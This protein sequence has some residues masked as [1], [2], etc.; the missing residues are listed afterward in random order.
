M[1][2]GLTFVSHNPQVRFMNNNVEGNGIRDAGSAQQLISQV[3]FNGM[4]CV[5]GPLCPDPHSLSLLLGTDPSPPDLPPCA[6]AMCPPLKCRTSTRV[7]LPGIARLRLMLCFLIHRPLGTALESKV[8][9][10]FLVSGLQKRDLQ[11]PILVSPV[12]FLPATPTVCRCGSCCDNF[13]VSRR[14]FT[15]HLF[16][17]MYCAARA[18]VHRHLRWRAC[19][20]APRHRQAR[21]PA[22]AQPHSCQR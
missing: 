13:A 11:K 22:G 16:R 14:C 8:I 17:L 20:R 2:V 12:R 4:T 9:R 7:Q 3:Q 15:C 6:R 10:P 19:R 21:H 5:P 18:A 1:M